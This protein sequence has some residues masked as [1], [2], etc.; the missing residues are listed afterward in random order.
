MVIFSVIVNPL[1]I[2][3]EH[4]LSKIDE[5]FASMAGGKIFSKIDLKQ[6]YLQLPLA[7]SDREILTLNIHKE[8]YQCNHLM[9]EVAT[10]LAIWQRTIE[11]ILSRISRVAVFLDD[12]KGKNLDEHIAR[13]KLVFM[14]HL[15]LDNC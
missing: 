12:I 15:E 4:P 6:A 11:N 9:Y 13:L 5:L 7:E 2:V 3:D 8:L 10:A 14:A 1:L